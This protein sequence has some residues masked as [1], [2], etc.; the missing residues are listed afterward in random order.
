[1]PGS[2]R[3][4]GI[5]KYTTPNIASVAP[6]MGADTLGQLSYHSLRPSV[7]LLAPVAL[8]CAVTRVA[9]VAFDFAPAICSD[10]PTSATAPATHSSGACVREADLTAPTTWLPETT[11]ARRRVGGRTGRPPHSVSCRRHARAW[12]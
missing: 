8:N 10:C 3:S 5:C 1:M 12:P 4:V 9:H 7:S 11:T 6:R 2:G